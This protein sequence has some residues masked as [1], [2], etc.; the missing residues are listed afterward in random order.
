MKFFIVIVL[1]VAGY[2][3]FHPSISLSETSKLHERVVAMGDK[4]PSIVMYSATTCPA[5]RKLKSQL[6]D[7]GLSYTEILL[8]QGSEEELRQRNSEVQQLLSENNIE[9]AVT[10]V[11]LINNQMVLPKE[12]PKLIND[13]DALVQRLEQAALHRRRS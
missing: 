11:V 13:A 7:L 6:K 12:I 8:D 9:V 2:F 4:T 3:W 1:M 10:P 5:C